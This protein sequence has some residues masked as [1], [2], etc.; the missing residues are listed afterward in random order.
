MVFKLTPD[1]YDNGIF[2]KFSLRITEKQTTVLPWTGEPF[3]TSSSVSIGVMTERRSSIAARL[4]GFV[5]KATIS[6]PTTS[7]IP[8]QARR[9]RRASWFPR[10]A[11]STVSRKAEKERN[12]LA[13]TLPE[14]RTTS[15]IPRDVIKRTMERDAP[16]LFQAVQQEFDRTLA[17]TLDGLKGL[18]MLVETPKKTIHFPFR[19][20]DREKS[21]GILH[22]SDEC[23][24]FIIIQRIVRAEHGNDMLARQKRSLFTC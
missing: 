17:P 24:E 9:E 10:P 14:L 15:R 12:A 1:F 18:A 8:S 6:L 22:M 2:C 23:H 16:A 4:S 5:M 20:H 7:P 13:S 21:D 19:N 3:V 11:S